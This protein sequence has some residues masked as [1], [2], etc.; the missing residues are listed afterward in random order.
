VTQE[1]IGCLHAF[2]LLKVSMHHLLGQRQL[3]AAKRQVVA[4]V[5]LLRQ[6]YF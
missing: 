4:Y 5:P 3:K 6:K 2:K 1:E